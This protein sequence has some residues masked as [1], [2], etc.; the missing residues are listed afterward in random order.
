LNPNGVAVEKNKVI[1][2]FLGFS[3]VVICSIV[4]ALAWIAIEDVR[5]EANMLKA[6]VES[7]GSWSKNWR[8]IPS[9]TKDEQPIKIELTFLT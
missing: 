1:V 9:C 3:A 4:I 8:Q 5:S 7:G 2:A 6:C